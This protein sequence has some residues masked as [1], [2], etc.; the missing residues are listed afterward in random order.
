MPEILKY[1]FSGVVGGLIVAGWHGFKDS[2][3]EDFV[4]QRFPRSLIIGGLVGFFIYFLNKEGLLKVDNLG[5]VTLSSVCLERFLGE[6]IKGFVKRRNHP[7]YISMFEKYYIP[8]KKYLFKFSL[9]FV[10]F[11]VVSALLIYTTRLPLVLGKFINDQ[12]LFGVLSGFIGGLSVA[13]GGAIKDSP[14][15]GFKPK[16]FIRSPIAGTIGGIIIINFV[17]SFDLLIIAAIGFE[18]IVVEFYKTFY[19][20]KPRGIFEGLKP[21][22]PE[23][24]GKRWIFF[25]PYSLGVIYAFL[26]LIFNIN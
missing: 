22:H 13:I 16:K 7:E 19:S 14:K 5:I 11:L 8:Y 3:W 26:M 21:E 25:V 17:K 20:R 6:V 1:I 12:I 23:W 18:R 9:G 10:F 15:E 24:F 4:I 2:P